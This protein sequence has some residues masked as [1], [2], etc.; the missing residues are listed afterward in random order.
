VNLLALSWDLGIVVAVLEFDGQRLYHRKE[1]RLAHLLVPPLLSIAARVCL[2]I[3][4]FPVC[5]TYFGAM[6]WY[7]DVK[8]FTIEK[9]YHFHLDRFCFLVDKISKFIV[10]YVLKPLLIDR[11]HSDHSD[12]SNIRYSDLLFISLGGGKRRSPYRLS[13]CRPSDLTLP[14][15]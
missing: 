15:Q 10:T 6:P 12:D 11:A 9:S 5:A 14:L 7:V 1:H 8:V 13:R 2:E 4:P 3:Q